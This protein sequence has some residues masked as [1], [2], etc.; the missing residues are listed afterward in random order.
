MVGDVTPVRVGLVGA[1][2]WASTMHAPLHSSGQGTVLSGVW[3]A[4]RERALVLAGQYGVPAFDTYQQL[5][6]AS[7][8]V[9]FAVPPA[10]Q[11][12]LAIRAAEA[13]K[14]LML[15]KPLAATL[16][17][18][19]E[20]VSAIENAGVATIVVFTKRFHPRTRAFLAEAAALRDSSPAIAVT[21][22]Y[23]H[24]GFLAT[25][26]LGESERTGWRDELGVLFDLGPHLLDL[27]EAAAGPIHTIGA[28]GNPRE[29]VTL[30]TTHADGAA[31]QLL[32]SGRVTVPRVLTDVDL[33]THAARL[34]YNTV[35]MDNNEAWPSLVSEFASAVRSGTPVT[36]DAVRAL[37]IQRLVE[38][39][40]LS[41]VE[42]RPVTLSEF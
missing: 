12:D 35:D 22:R 4:T 39:A 15:E 19:E 5:L 14:A 26:F 23:V 40:R 6:D 7:E 21:A 16:A 41:L 42:N 31:G 20:L 2:Q 9:D 1:G 29:A 10:V 3:S 37:A 33:F 30:A 13:G 24:G 25:G 18:A 8:A 28:S 11:G 38:A 17:K 36:V 32:L 27:V 34:A